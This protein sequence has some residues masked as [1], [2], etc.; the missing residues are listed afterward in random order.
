[1]EKEEP[2]EVVVVV[3]RDIVMMVVV[4]VVVWRMSRKLLSKVGGCFRKRDQAVRTV[5]CKPLEERL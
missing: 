1:M 4:M 2:E 3:E 5:F